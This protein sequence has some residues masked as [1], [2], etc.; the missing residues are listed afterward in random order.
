MLTRSLF[1]LP[2]D[3]SHCIFF[4]FYTFPQSFNQ[5]FL[6]V[7]VK[8]CDNVSFQFCVYCKGASESTASKSINFFGVN[9]WIN[10]DK[11]RNLI[12]S[13]SKPSLIL[14]GNIRSEIFICFSFLLWTEFFF[15]F[16]NKIGFIR[17]FARDIFLHIVHLILT[18]VTYIQN[19]KATY[20]AESSPFLSNV[21]LQDFGDRSSSKYL[22]FVAVAKFCLSW[23][24]LTLNIYF[25][26][27]HK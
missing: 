15:F 19:I 12:V 21:H 10:K 8:L 9:S 26:I 22:C 3:I 25:D 2:S 1:C 4:L 16:L 18:S 20:I 27:N 17:R 11:I 14:P 24:L 23:S 7:Y 13:Y 6:K 5:L